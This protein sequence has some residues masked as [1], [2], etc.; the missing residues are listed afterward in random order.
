MVIC[1]LS[2]A[3]LE[4]KTMKQMA[5]AGPL[6]Y[7]TFLLPA[8]HAA[9]SVADIHRQ[10]ADKDATIAALR[11]QVA[12]QS[13]EI[14][15]L[16]QQV[17]LLT[18]LAASQVP[19]PASTGTAPASAPPLTRS[20]STSSPQL[21]NEA[22][23]YQSLSA[24][25]NTTWDDV[26]T[27]ANQSKAQLKIAKD[28]MATDIDRMGEI[29]A[30]IS[31]DPALSSKYVVAGY[32][33][34]SRMLA[35]CKSELEIPIDTAAGLPMIR[36]A[37]GA[38]GPPIGSLRSP[39]EASQKNPYAYN[40]R[41][42]YRLKSNDVL[43]AESAYAMSNPGFQAEMLTPAQIANLFGWSIDPKTGRFYSPSPG[44]F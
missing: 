31:N 1:V 34:D 42:R 41:N 36:S 25:A 6:L 40:P 44:G 5:A 19:P 29:Y 2:D 26:Q 18:Q 16:Q 4:E 10:F 43:N 17:A 20:Q 38:N 11:Q 32:A 15:E 28:Q 35:Y 3:L 21:D 27:F 23:L 33:L 9:P 14:K 37:A 8:A 13:A 30:D 12:E 22:Q 7:L 24:D 39:P